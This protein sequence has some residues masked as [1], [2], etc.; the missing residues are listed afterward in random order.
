VPA[1]VCLVDAIRGTY[2]GDKFGDA[3]EGLGDINGDGYNDFVLAEWGGSDSTGKLHLYLGG[4]HPFDNPPAITWV[5]H[6]AYP[7][8]QS[9]FIYNVGDIDCDGVNDFLTMFG[10]MEKLVLFKDLEVMNPQGTVIAVRDT[11][12]TWLEAIAC[13]GGDNNNDGRP[14]VWVF[15]NAMSKNDTIWGYIGC[16]LFDSIPDL[17]IVRSRMPDYHYGGLGAEICNTCDING[18]SIPEIIFGQ[19]G[20]SG[21]AGR[22]CV[23]WGSEE[24][25]AEPDLVFYAPFDHPGNHDFG[26]DLACLGDISGD[27]IDDIWVS[28]G[29]RNYIYYGGRPFDTIPDWA[30]DWS[31]MYADIENVGD[32]NGDGWNDVGLF[33]DGF[34]INWTSFIYCYPGMDTL[35]DVSFR[36]GDYYDA[37]RDGPLCCVGID[38]S[39]V[40]DVNGDG[41]NDVLLSACYSNIE[42]NDYGR[43]IIQS[44]WVDPVSADDQSEIVPDELELRQNHPNPFNAG[45]RIEFTLPRDGYTELRIYNLLGELVTTLVQQPLATGTHSV[46][47]DGRDSE[48]DLAASGIYFYH[49]LS[50][51]YVSAK[52]MMLLK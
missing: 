47:W 3:C 32:I 26:R 44:G 21:S 10:Y 20:S 5:D 30:M 18:D 31:F 35:V 38:H 51:D 43:S 37:I 12:L 50:G 14:E 42:G 4:P 9:H 48:G 11:N 40:G 1:E 27:G 33:F 13:G 34:L 22:V 45:T 17:K 7:E 41:I 52:K 39:W 19:P 46:I 36:D 24:L 23:V 15:P 2:A 49:L 16:D 29:G 28:Q 8:L 25:S 6:T